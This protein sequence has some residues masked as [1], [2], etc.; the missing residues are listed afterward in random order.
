M[1]DKYWPAS[2]PL[3]CSVILWSVICEAFS[4][5]TREN[6]LVPSQLSG[7]ASAVVKSSWAWLFFTFEWIDVGELAEPRTWLKANLFSVKISWFPLRLRK[8][9]L[10]SHM[11]I[12]KKQC[13]LSHMGLLLLLWGWRFW[14]WL[15]FPGWCACVSES[16]AFA[17]CFIRWYIQDWRFLVLGLSLSCTQKEVMSVLG[18]AWQKSNAQHILG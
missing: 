18:S 7:L 16:N 14:S 4:E 13:W 9:I 8:Q 15:M 1:H 17:C 12:L 6:E 11:G 5:V 10:C 2:C 3:I